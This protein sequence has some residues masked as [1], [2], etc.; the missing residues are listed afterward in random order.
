MTLFIAIGF[1]AW[2]QPAHTAPDCG[3]SA[4][5]QEC[6]TCCGL[7]VG[8]GDKPVLVSSCEKLNTVTSAQVV[9]AA[10]SM[11]AELGLTGSSVIRICGYGD[12]E[13]ADKQTAE[14]RGEAKKPDD[15]KMIASAQGPIA[16]TSKE[17]L[18]KC[19]AIRQIKAKAAIK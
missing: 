8:S 2:A 18:R 9:E 1:L 12:R 4:T 17:C 6:A 5:P 14:M 15:S 16:E 10:L 13:K 11:G 19:R 3:K 7:A